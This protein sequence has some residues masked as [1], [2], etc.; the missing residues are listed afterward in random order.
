[1]K[2]SEIRFFSLNRAFFLK[3]SPSG[4]W[5]HF[6]PTVKNKSSNKNRDLLDFWSKQ[7]IPRKR[8]IQKL[9][10]ESKDWSGLKDPIWLN[11]LNFFKK[12]TIALKSPKKKKKIVFF[13][14]FFLNVVE[15][16]VSFVY[17]FGLNEVESTKLNFELSFCW[18][19]V[20]KFIPVFKGLSAFT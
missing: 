4:I 11:W 20:L 5:R 18:F 8:Y 6:F 13:C 17:P 7:N 10:E 9:W 2:W 15:G 16:V 19:W 12:N 3:F 1:M 14:F